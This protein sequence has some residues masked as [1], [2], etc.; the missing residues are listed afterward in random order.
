MS[1][2]NCRTDTGL[3]GIIF[4][5]T[6]SLNSSEYL[7]CISSTRFAPQYCIL[8]WG[9]RY[10]DTQGMP[11]Y[12]LGDELDF[13]Y[14]INSH[15][16]VDLPIEYEHSALNSTDKI[17]P[18]AISKLKEIAAKVDA[19]AIIGLVNNSYFGWGIASYYASALAV[20]K[21][22][23]EKDRKDLVSCLLPLQTSVDIENYSDF[24]YG[25][26]LMARH[27]LTTK[28]YYVLTPTS[29]S[30]GNS[31]LTVLED[32]KARALDEYVEANEALKEGASPELLIRE[33]IDGEKF[34]QFAKAFNNPFEIICGMNP[35]IIVVI[36]YGKSEEDGVYYFQSD[37]ISLN[38]NRS[39]LP[40]TILPNTILQNT[41]FLSLFTNSSFAYYTRFTLGPTSS[42]EGTVFKMLDEMPSIEY[43][44]D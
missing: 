16:F 9:E 42:L 18:K 43:R 41:I 32:Y 27:L 23:V 29:E 34:G 19:D 40:N 38:K 6:D 8:N 21:S 37:A 36:K 2:H 33:I 1:L 15:V 3:G 22:M 44:V 20:N 24:D 17:P 31:I 35:D 11:V 26:R 25:V 12:K 5:M 13:R 10:P 30:I 4:L 28:G 14:S 39:I 7:F